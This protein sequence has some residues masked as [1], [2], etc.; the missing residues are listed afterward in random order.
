MSELADIQAKY[1]GKDYKE[2]LYEYGV[3]PRDEFLA[4]D[5]D[6][7]GFQNFRNICLEHFNNP[8]KLKEKIQED[9]ESFKKQ[10]TG[11]SDDLEELMND[12]IEKA[13]NV[14]I[15]AESLYLGGA[16]RIGFTLGIVL[17]NNSI[18]PVANHWLIVS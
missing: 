5:D 16:A 4:I 2:D 18:I 11:L 13:H 8:N 7:E 12:L 9:L 14:N 17:K 1:T 10:G 15:I 3:I 6:S